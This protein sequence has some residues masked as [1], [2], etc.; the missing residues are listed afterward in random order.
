MDIA[1]KTKEHYLDWSKSP[2]ETKLFGLLSSGY[3]IH[4]KNPHLNTY[5]ND[6]VVPFL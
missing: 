4:A 1:I 3:A 2:K 6:P 5:Y